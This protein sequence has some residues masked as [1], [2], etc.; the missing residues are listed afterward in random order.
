MAVS[1]R[2]S[3][4]RLRHAARL[5]LLAC[6]AC[7]LALLAPYRATA[8][9]PHGFID[10]GTV[11]F[12]TDQ[13]PSDIDPA[14]NEVAGSDVVARS[15]AEPLVAPDGS[16]ITR[17]KPVLATSWKTNKNQSVWTFYLRRGVKFHT[18]RC[19]LTADDVKYSLARTMLAGLTNSFGLARFMSNPNKQIKIVNSYTVEFD[20]NGS[21]PLFIDQLSSLYMSLI[22]DA[23]ALRKH[24]KIV[25]GKSD[26]S[27]PW[28]EFQDL[29]TGPYM[30]QNWQHGQQVTMVRFP[31]YWG[32]W[33]GRHFSKVVMQTVPEITTR[34]ELVEKGQADLTF[35]LNPQDYVALSKNPAVKVVAPYGTEVE[36]IYM[37]EAGPLASKY[38][39]QA[40]SYA[41]NYDAMIKGILK[42]YARRAYGCLPSTMLG[43]DP[44]VFHY[45][46]DLNKARQLL[47]KA[48][49][50]PGTVLTYY[51]ADPYGPDGQILQ[52]QLA[53]LGITLKLQK[54]DEA[55]YQTVLYSN[56]DPNKR[57]NLMAWGWWPDFNDPYDECNIL[58]NS[59]SAGA[60]GANAGYYHNSQVDAILNK[61][62]T[63]GGETLI[64]LAHQLQEVN[65]EDPSAIWVDEP[66]QATVLAKNLQGYVFN[67]VELQTYDFYSMYR[68]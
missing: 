53:Q 2:D 24:E 4:R 22:L 13:S 65:A 29:G 47:Q 60:S 45:N 21:Q 52:A 16:S 44:N 23:Q 15:V 54:L 50:K 43:Y 17:F 67:P 62:K 12:V 18:G 58:L 64:S 40:L 5:S 11:T 9:N 68:S 10:S 26:Y 14:N 46:T 35:H 39:R 55:P 7:G 59:A 38:A 8:Q 33:N 3:T 20:L 6:L 27:R 48:G 51:Y 49:V 56:G 34:R 32:G 36:Y 31:D 28:A 19:C 66:A 30:I 37:T 63:A 42:G 57:P 25:N 61:M 1:T 41:F